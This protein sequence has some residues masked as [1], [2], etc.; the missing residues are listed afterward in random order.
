VQD[1][2]ERLIP[3]PGPGSTWRKRDYSHFVL[4]RFEEPY[5]KQEAPNETI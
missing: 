3:G 4:L 1:L 2:L 5:P